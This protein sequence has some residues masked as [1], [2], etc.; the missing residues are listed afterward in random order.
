MKTKERDEQKKREIKLVKK[1]VVRQ[2][3]KR[4][5]VFYNTKIIP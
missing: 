3:G 1:C 4:K 2:T 5:K